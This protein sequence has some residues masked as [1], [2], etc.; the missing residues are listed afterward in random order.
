[1]IQDKSP[2]A[3]AEQDLEYLYKDWFLDYASYTILD[4]AVPHILD[5]F[6]PVQRRIMHAMK[7]LDD[8]KFNKV[9]N[10]VGQSMQYHPHGDAAIFEAIVKLGQKDLLIETQGNWG[11]MRTGDAAAAARYIEARLSKFALEVLFN[12]K[13][14]PWG[15]SYDGRKK[16]PLCFPVKFPLLLVQGAYGIAVGLSTEVLPHNFNEV[17][18]AAIRHLQGKSFTLYPDFPTGAQI[19]VCKYQDGKKGGKIKCRATI[20][21]I[22]KNTLLIKDVP[23]KRTTEQICASI[24]QASEK[25]K[26]KIKKVTDNTAKEVAIQVDL[27]PGVAPGLAIEAL[28]AFTECATSYAPNACVIADNRPLF[29]SVSELLRYSVARTQ[30]LLTQELTLQLAQLEEEWHYSSLEKIFIEH[31]IYTLIEEERTWEG[32]M[33]ATQQ[34]LAPFKERLRKEITQDDIKKLLEIPIRK[35]S[36]YDLKK[37]DDLIADIDKRIAHTQEDLTHIVVYTIAYFKTLKQK[38]GKGRERLSKIELF[39]SIDAKTVA[40]ADTK[41]YINRTEGFIGTAL[42]K[43]ELLATCSGLDDVIV[44]RKDGVMLVTKVADK[45][46]VGRDILHAEIFKKEE[47]QVYHLIYVDGAT[48]TTYA[49]RFNVKGITRDR[50]Y[51][52]IKAHAQS[53]VLYFSVNPNGESEEVEVLLSPNCG[54][55]K[56]VWRYDFGALAVKNRS[57]QGVQLTKYPVRQ[58]KLKA[59][60]D[61]TWADVILYYDKISGRLVRQ[62][63]LSC[64]DLGAFGVSDY[65]LAVFA[66]GTYAFYTPDYTPKIEDGQL[67][68]IQKWSEGMVISVVYRTTNP[69]AW[70]AKRFATGPQEGEKNTKHVFLKEAVVALASCAVQPVALA[71]A[72]KRQ[73]IPEQRFNIADLAPLTA[74]KNKGVLLS[75]DVKTVWSWAA[76]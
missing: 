37:A 6:K 43:D 31:K 58:I 68:L 71:A 34:G 64:E 27:A 69:A 53:K 35:I 1:M 41:L 12:P 56:K 46:F 42:K 76:D 22:D 23:Y 74:L 44:F 55:K 14:T 39:D 50:E 51:P 61:S 59:K 8:G 24:V 7:E 72:R 48:K 45:A 40:V 70:W 49:K 36:K 32:V 54:A 20:E 11:D 66:D 25:G 33:A 75:E 17:I 47:R 21:A 29:L 10:I 9:A 2:V 15:V 38:Y 62:P 52:L 57:V 65:V 13:I 5:G 19:D 18:E 30:D 16:E 3:G 60:G 4:R 73:N 26:I 28:Y 67:L 63:S